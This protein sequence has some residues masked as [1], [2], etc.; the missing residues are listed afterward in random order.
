LVSVRVAVDV[1]VAVGEDRVDV[2]VAVKEAV[3]VAVIV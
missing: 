3:V 1:E 2:G